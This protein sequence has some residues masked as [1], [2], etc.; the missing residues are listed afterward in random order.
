M[1]SR[2][3]PNLRIWNLRN[4]TN[5]FFTHSKRP[6]NNFLRG[7]QQRMF[8]LLS[9]GLTFSKLSKILVRRSIMIYLIFYSAS[10]Q[11]RFIRKHSEQPTSK[12]RSHTGLLCTTTMA[13]ARWAAA[14]MQ[15]M[16]ARTKKITQKIRAKEGIWP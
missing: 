2:R 10:T 12:T 15:E 16:T 1:S 8:G 13:K 6:N 3:T 5:K 9:H 14:S 11:W 4:S 7:K